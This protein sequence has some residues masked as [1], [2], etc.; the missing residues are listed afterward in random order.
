[1]EMAKDPHDS[2]RKDE[3]IMG[4][5]ILIDIK[6]RSD[7]VSGKVYN[8]VLKEGQK[9]SSTRHGDKVIVRQWSKNKCYHHVKES[10]TFCKARAWGVLLPTQYGRCLTKVR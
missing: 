9:K 7:E 5:C 8:E 4:R 3:L 1:M 10:Q 2:R 6:D